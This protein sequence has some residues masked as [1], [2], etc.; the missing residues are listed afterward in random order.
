MKIRKMLCAMTMVSVLGLTSAT[1]AAAPATPAQDNDK[2]EKRE[3]RERHP[4]IRKAIEQ[5]KRAKADMQ[6]A[7]HDFGGHRDAALKACDEAIE[8]L[9]QALNYDKK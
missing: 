5:L 7:S 1:F 4:E 6:H 9:Q 3:G 8:Q 2:M